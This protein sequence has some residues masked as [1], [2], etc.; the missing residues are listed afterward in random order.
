MCRY[1]CLY[2]KIVYQRVALYQLLVLEIC[3]FEIFEMFF[4]KHKKQENMLKRQPFSKGK[5]RLLS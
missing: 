4:Y 3:A 2:M 1:L 5:S